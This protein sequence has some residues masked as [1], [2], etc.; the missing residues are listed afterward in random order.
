MIEH[1]GWA[2]GTVFQMRL[3]GLPQDLGCHGL[4]IA[5]SR[6]EQLEE[7]WSRFR[8][9]SEV[10]QLNRSAGSPR[11]VTVETLQLID[12][13]VAGWL[14]TGGLFDP[15]VHEAVVAA[16]YDRTWAQVRAD[17]TDHPT[18]TGGAVPVPGCAGI[19]LDPQS[20]QV[21]LPSGTRLD[22][23]GIGKGRTADVL[24]AELGN[25]GTGLLVNLGGDL[26]VSG[27]PTG[28]EPWRI[29][30]ADPT[31]PERIL[32]HLVLDEGAVATSSTTTRSWPT[33]EGPCHHLIDP[34]SGGPSRSGLQAVTVVAAEAAWAEI[35][36]K[37]VLVAGAE[38]GL[39]LL[40]DADLAGLLVT[41]EG[42]LLATQSLLAH[43]D[44]A[45]LAHAEIQEAAA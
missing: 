34:R 4:R 44:P 17:P 7:L 29:A 21:S 11:S 16:G 18:G 9:T 1:F 30:V 26:R 41:D 38:Q 23:G 25:Q 33:P 37:A 42:R 14:R 45:D 35:Y 5:E 12:L 19:R 22:L 13:A 39:D 6:L 8:P 2:M 24:T 32:V 31:R 3:Y 20:R 10:C 40:Q 27:Q 15:T 36:A 28:G 43:L